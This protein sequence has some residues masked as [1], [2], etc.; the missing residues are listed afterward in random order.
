MFSVITRCFYAARQETAYCRSVLKLWMMSL[1]GD[2]TTAKERRNY[3]LSARSR[4]L[5]NIYCVK[6]D[7]W[8]NLKKNDMSDLP[9]AS[10]Y[11]QSMHT[12]L[13]TYTVFYRCID[14]YASVRICMCMS[15]ICVV[16]MHL[17]TPSCYELHIQ[18]RKH[19]CT[20]ILL[21]LLCC[22]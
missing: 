5:Y 16:S 9:I 7:L 21:L 12:Y 15:G 4:M 19:E 11:V 2:H 14:L 22:I 6:R 1:T 18:V 3:N 10:A 20:S 17:N 8:R 13:C